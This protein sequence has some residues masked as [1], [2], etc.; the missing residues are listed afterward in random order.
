[1]GRGEMFHIAIQGPRLMKTL[2][3]SALDLQGDPGHGQSASRYKK[4][5][6]K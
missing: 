1:M 3:S 4:R 6:S 5:A 2:L